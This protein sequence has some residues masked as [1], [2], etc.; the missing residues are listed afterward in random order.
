MVN[1]KPGRNLVATSDCARRL[2]YTC[3]CA[4]LLSSN[5]AREGGGGPELSFPVKKT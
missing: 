3:R 5:W 1:N 2:F 4:Q